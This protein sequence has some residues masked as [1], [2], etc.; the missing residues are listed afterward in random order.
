MSEELKFDKTPVVTPKHYFAP[1]DFETAFGFKSIEL[2]CANLIDFDKPFD[3]LVVSAY[4]H[5]YAP[6]QSTLIGAL[7]TSCNIDVEKLA[8]DPA[9]DLRYSQNVWLSR[10]IGYL[11]K[12]FRIA[13]VEVDYHKNSYDSMAEIDH[14][15]NNLFSLLAFASYQGIKIESTA[16]PLLGTN[17]LRLPESA[18]IECILKEG[19]HALENIA[20]FTNLHIVEINM[21][22]CIKLA[23]GM[24]TFLDRTRINSTKIPDDP[25]TIQIVKQIIF[26]LN[27]ISRQLKNSKNKVIDNI[28]VSALIDFKT[29]L[30][31]SER[32]RGADILISCRR[33]LESLMSYMSIK[34]NIRAG[35]ILATQIDTIGE[36]YSLQGWLTSYMHLIRRLG[37]ESAHFPTLDKPTNRYPETDDL[38]IVFYVYLGC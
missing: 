5:H 1:Y 25:Y 11:N 35:N 31:Q 9:I 22:K 28:N 32:L 19:R 8:Q 17:K 6:V 21:E 34:R 30:Q 20:D 13:C 10:A 15:L 38:R 3:V 16:M 12:T 26:D 29:K 18:M 33:I 27:A 37:N 2:H 24:D 23:N 36:K 14:L 7:H 4:K